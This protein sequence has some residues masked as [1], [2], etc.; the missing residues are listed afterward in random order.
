[1]GIFSDRVTDF[2]TSRGFHCEHETP[3]G[4]Y[5]PDGIETF[6]A[7]SSDGLVSRRIVLI[8]PEAKTDEEAARLSAEEALRMLAQKRDNGSITEEEYQA[9]RA[10]I[11]RSL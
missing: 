8:S 3:A 1:M 6:L 7:T 2:L 5:I 10:E 4:L 11:I 9:L